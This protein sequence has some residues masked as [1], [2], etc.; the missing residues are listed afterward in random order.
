MMN[1]KVYNQP[2]MWISIAH[3]LGSTLGAWF[4]VQET[5]LGLTE[6]QDRK[7]TLT[8]KGYGAVDVWQISCD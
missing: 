1:P 6:E 5:I 4:A 7:E 2:T 3:R 8:N